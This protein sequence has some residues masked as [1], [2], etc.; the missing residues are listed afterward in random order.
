[1][2]SPGHEALLKDNT[3]GDDDFAPPP[4]VVPYNQKSG[5][6]Y[7]AQ[8]EMEKKIRKLEEDN[9]DL[10]AQLQHM[11]SLQQRP[12]VDDDH[13]HVGSSLLPTDEK[14]TSFATSPSQLQQPR[15]LSPSEDVDSD[16]D[17]EATTHCIQWCFTDYE[18]DYLKREADP[19]KDPREFGFY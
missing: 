18:R 11:Q 6:S 16:H 10:K 8:R 4:F 2:A 12:S 14:S 17:H 3:S 19:K 9:R 5:R 13:P 1:M 15:A 7:K